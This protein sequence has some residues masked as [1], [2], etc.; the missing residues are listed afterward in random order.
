MHRDDLKKDFILSYWIG[1][2]DLQIDLQGLG[3]AAYN[4]RKKK[5]IGEL[6]TI[7]KIVIFAVP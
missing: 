6:G 4:L 3:Y 7:A 5:D 2:S 1:T